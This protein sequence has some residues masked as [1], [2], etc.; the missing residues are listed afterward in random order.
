MF[1]DFVQHGHRHHHSTAPAGRSSSARH[2]PNHESANRL[3]QAS[4]D[5]R[6]GFF[7]FMDFTKLDG[8][9]PAVIQDDVSNEVLMVGFM[10]QEAL[11]RTV[12]TGFATFFSRTR[13]KLWMKGE[14]SGNRLRVERMLV[15]CDED[16]VLVR[17]TQARRRQRVPHRRADAVSTTQLPTRPTEV[18][19]ANKLKLGIPKG[20]LQDATIQL[21][22]RA[23][24]NIYAST[25][26]YFPG[27]RRSGDRLH[28]DPRAGD[29]ALR[30]RRRARR[31]ADRA[32]TGSPST[33]PA[34]A[35]GE[36]PAIVPLADLIYAKQ[37]FGK[38]RWV[39]AV[40]EDSTYRTP[41]DLEGA[42]IA[43]ELVRATQAY[44]ARLG[45]QRQRRVLLGRDRG[46]AADARRRDRRSH[47]NRV[48]AA[49]QPAAHHRHGPR[50]EHAAHRQRRARSTTSGSGRSSRTSRCC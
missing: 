29:G 31:R 43:T 6:R 32:R 20:S 23:G 1:R 3:H 30:R 10:N 39:L 16:T 40:P 38:V 4:P 35:G 18:T 21:F 42:T 47:R 27:D 36:A 12:A 50:V 46:Q 41:Q 34:T 22:A 8:L 45:V 19:M 33:P 25:R 28:A 44:F 37:S 49:R 24:F 48:V 9:I 15:D 26:S 14:T 5:N 11:D 17:V 13:G 7:A 2:S